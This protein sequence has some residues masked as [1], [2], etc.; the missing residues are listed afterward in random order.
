MRVFLWLLLFCDVLFHLFVC[1][2][3]LWDFRIPSLWRDGFVWGK[4]G[5][6]G[7]L[8]FHREDEFST[9]S[10]CLSPDFQEN[11]HKQMHLTFLWVLSHKVNC[12][13]LNFYWWFLLHTAVTVPGGLLWKVEQKRKIL[14]RKLDCLVSWDTQC[15][16]FI[17]LWNVHQSH[18]HSDQV[19]PVSET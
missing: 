19:W 13:M 16:D 10:E 17:G 3:A 14:Q 7:K 18:L 12:L 2:Q 6:P 11:E 15:M 8:W 1:C 9:S 5:R 4:P